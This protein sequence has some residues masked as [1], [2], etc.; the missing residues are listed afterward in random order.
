M[1]WDGRANNNFFAGIV[2]QEYDPINEKLVGSPV[3]IFKGT[4][5]GC[6][7]GP[8]LLKKDGYYY[9][10]T[11]EGGTAQD[12]AVSI[13]R[14]KNITGPYEI[15]PDNPILTSRFQ[16]HAELSRAGHGFFVETQN[17]EWYLSHLCG[18]RIPNPEGYQFIPK[19]NNGFSILGRETA[20]QKV[21]WEN[22]W[23]YVTTGK[24]PVVTF[25]ALYP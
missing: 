11:A 19:Y 12:H 2:L 5:L 23:P 14:S 9:L 4:E 3:N 25:P 6:T 24:T 18:R 15:H 13:C 16:E 17:G 7:E 10:I 1:V 21:H 20:L 22:D 8:Q